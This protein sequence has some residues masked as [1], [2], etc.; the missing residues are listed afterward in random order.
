[1]KSISNSDF[2]LLLEKLPVVLQ[3]ARAAIPA[4][5]LKAVNDARMLAVF[6]SKHKKKLLASYGDALSHKT[7]KNTENEKR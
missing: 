6:V 7:L 1:M 3:Y 2:S 5:D 4:S